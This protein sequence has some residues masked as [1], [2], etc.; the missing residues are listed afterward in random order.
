M[1]VISQ[2]ATRYYYLK[3]HLGSVKMTV[4]TSGT[5]VG[6]DDYYPYGSVLNGRS[7][8]SS[9]DQRYKFTGKERNA[10]TGL[11]YFGAR[12]YDSWRIH[13]LQVDPMADKYA[14]WSPYNYCFNNPLNLVDPNGC[15]VIDGVD[16][17]KKT[18]DQEMRNPQEEINGKNGLS[19]SGYNESMGLINKEFLVPDHELPNRIAANGGKKAQ[20][21]NEGAKIAYGE[22]SGLRAN[23]PKSTELLQLARI[24]IILV[25]K[26]NSTVHSSSPENTDEA[27]RIYGDCRDAAY[28]A[29]FC[30]LPPTVKHFFFIQKGIGSQSP[31]D[32][33]NVTEYRRFGPFKNIGGGDVPKGD[34]TFI[35]LYK[36]N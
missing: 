8:I 6:Y 28:L 3:D 27:K 35:I 29:K 16:E 11:D 20:S 17:K 33:W 19:N 36:D 2:A 7:Y 26:R 12:D 18:E 25:S 21:I 9:A 14:G 5:V 31:P 4:D 1:K 15:W 30:S 32:N 13:W 24:G 23:D 34:S 10:T 22:T